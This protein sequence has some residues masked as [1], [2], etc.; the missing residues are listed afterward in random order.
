MPNMLVIVMKGFRVVS[1]GAEALDM[2]P[3]PHGEHGHA[4]SISLWCSQTDL[5]FMVHWLC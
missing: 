2:A 1:R 5:D 3:R 4:S